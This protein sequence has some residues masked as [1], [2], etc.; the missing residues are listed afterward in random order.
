MEP[1]IDVLE[2]ELSQR[3][4]LHPGLSQDLKETSLTMATEQRFDP[5]VMATLLSL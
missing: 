5:K 1:A 4:V 3:E 2:R